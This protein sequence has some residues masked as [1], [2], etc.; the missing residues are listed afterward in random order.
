LQLTVRGK[1]IYTHVFV[2]QQLHSAA[3]LGIDSISRLRISYS[4]RKECFFFDNILEQK[5]AER[6][7]I[8][9]NQINDLK[10]LQRKCS[11][12]QK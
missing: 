4:G 5:D 1:S 2:C 3:I 10:I 8:Q 7:F 9:T 11:Q 12:Q 6:F